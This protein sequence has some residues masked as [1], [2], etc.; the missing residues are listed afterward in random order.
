MNHPGIDSPGPRNTLQHIQ[1][2]SHLI[3]TTLAVQGD[4]GSRSLPDWFEIRA[5]CKNVVPISLP[6]MQLQSCLLQIC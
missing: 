1:Q 6:C 4:P 5:G 3:D 2:Q